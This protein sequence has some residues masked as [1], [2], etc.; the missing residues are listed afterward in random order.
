MQQSYSDKYKALF[1]FFF[2]LEQSIVQPQM[3][4]SCRAFFT[5]DL[6]TWRRRKGNGVDN[7]TDGFVSLQCFAKEF[8][9][10]TDN[11]YFPA[12]TPT[13]SIFTRDVYMPWN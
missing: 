11:N 13:V 4:I 3:L 1:F 6:A 9:Q 8:W 2:L 5:A 10:N 12:P 7:K